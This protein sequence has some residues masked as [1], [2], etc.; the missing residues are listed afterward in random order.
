[1]VA[2]NK[3]IY[4]YAYTNIYIHIT[5]YKHIYAYTNI[6]EEEGLIKLMNILTSL[7][8]SAPSNTECS[9]HGH[10]ED[11]GKCH[12]FHSYVTSPD[13]QSCLPPSGRRYLE[14]KDEHQTVLK[15][16]KGFCPDVD[17]LLEMFEVDHEIGAS[18]QAFFGNI[19]TALLQM[20]ESGACLPVLEED[21][22]A[23]P[24]RETSPTTYGYAILA[25]TIVTLVSVVG[26]AVVPCMIKSPALGHWLIMALVSLA[27]GVTFGDAILHLIPEALGVHQH[28]ESGELISPS[29]SKIMGI[30]NTIIGGAVFLIIFDFFME[31]FGLAHKHIHTHTPTKIY[32]ERE[33]EAGLHNLEIEKQQFK[34]DGKGHVQTVRQFISW[35]EVDSVVWNITIGEAI[36]NFVDGLAIGAAFAEGTAGGISTTIAVVIHELPQ[37]FGDFGIY[38]KSGTGYIRALALNLLSGAFAIIGSAVG[39]SLGE[40]SVQYVLGIYIYIYIY[41]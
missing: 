23:S 15:E 8:S 2:Q 27:T 13:G 28:G 33:E 37:E 40:G 25:S 14:A 6:Q 34:D 12:C 17:T 19:T 7:T 4:I 24:S 31:A 36:H 35:K 16:T 3:Y 32:G 29:P 41:I 10:L 9:G 39:V 30:T 11:D 20:V 26:A 5:P 38:V 1:M 21:I 22:T 18:P